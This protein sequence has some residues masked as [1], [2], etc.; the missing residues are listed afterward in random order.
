MRWNNRMMTRSS[1]KMWCW[2]ATL[3]LALAPLTVLGQSCRATS[4]P[5]R[6]EWRGQDY[7]VDSRLLNGQAIGPARTFTVPGRNFANCGPFGSTVLAIQAR[8]GTYRDSSGLWT[9]PLWDAVGYKIYVGGSEFLGEKRQTYTRNATYPTTVIS[10]QPFLRDKGKLM[11]IS[12]TGTDPPGPSA[13]F[14]GGSNE[15]WVF[16]SGRSDN[17]TMKVRTCRVTG[18]SVRL[19]D[20]RAGDFPS[21][22]AVSPQSAASNVTLSCSYAPNIS[23]TLTTATVAGTTSVI[24]LTGGPGSA[25][26]LGV[27]VMHGSAVLVRNTARAVQNNASSTVNVPISGRYYRTGDLRPGTANAVATLRFTY[28]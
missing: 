12:G 17:F 22:G 5:A 2:L 1:R 21:V 14:N 20:F 25:S 9:H 15:A 24:P 27:Q 11:G 6:L 8:F 3:M 23:M 13:V 18:T 28:Y 26:G 16:S 4:G 19:G 10:I 7:D